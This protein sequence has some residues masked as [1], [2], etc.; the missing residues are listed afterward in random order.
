MLYLSPHLIKRTA[1]GQTTVPADEAQFRIHYFQDRTE[2]GSYD[3]IFP[4]YDWLILIRGPYNSSFR[5]ELSKIVVQ[6]RNT[7]PKI[8]EKSKNPKLIPK[9]DMTLL[10]KIQKSKINSEAWYNFI[11]FRTESINSNFQGGGPGADSP[12]VKKRKKVCSSEAEH[13]ISSRY[14]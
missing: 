4:G 1:G 9:L 11:N 13:W 5:P 6:I 8:H 12:P 7:Y 2:Y 14:A 10:E 3:P